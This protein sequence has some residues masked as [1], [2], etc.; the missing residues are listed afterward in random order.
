M[1]P[2][3]ITRMELDDSLS[4]YG[5]MQT[6]FAEALANDRIPLEVEIM[7]RST[8]AEMG[9][10]VGSQLARQPLLE[11]AIQ[12]L[13]TILRRIPQISP[14]RLVF[15]NKLCEAYY[16]LYC[17]GGSQQALE[18]SVL[19][20]RQAND[21]LIAYGV[22]EGNLD[23]HL[24]ILTNLGHSLVQ[25]FEL[26]KNPP[27]LE[28]SIACKREILAKAPRNSDWYLTA[29]NNLASSLRLRYMCTEED[30]N[31]REASELFRELLSSA[32]PGTPMHNVAIGQI[33][34]TAAMKF[35]IK[36]T[37]E[38]LDDAIAN[39]KIGLEAGGPVNDGWMAMLSMLVELCTEKFNYTGNPTDLEVLINASWRQFESIPAGHQ[40][41]GKVFL[42]HIETLRECAF[43]LQSVHMVEHISEECH[44]ALESMPADS[45]TRTLSQV[46]YSHILGH[47]YCLSGSLLDLIDLVEHSLSVSADFNALV[48]A[49]SSLSLSEV[50]RYWYPDLASRLH[51]LARASP[52][53]P[54]RQTAEEEM[55]AIFKSHYD[56]EAKR[57]ALMALDG[58]FEYNTTRLQILTAAAANNMNLS[59]DEIERK[60]V[61]LYTESDEPVEEQNEMPEEPV[62]PFDLFHSQRL[63]NIDPQDGH[64]VF[65]IKDWVKTLIGQDDGLRS[66]SGSP[67]VSV[68]VDNNER[69][70]R[71]M[72]RKAH[73]A[74]R[75]TNPGLCYWCQW[76][77]KLV[78]PPGVGFGF[79]PEDTM[80]PSIGDWK[81]TLFRKRE[82]AV[83]SLAAS[84]ITTAKGQLHAYFEKIE[85]NSKRIRFI[86]GRLP[87][88]EGVLRVDV[89][90]SCAGELRVL[91][92]T[93]FRQ[94]LRQAWEADVDTSNTFEALSENTD[95]PVHD[96]GG[97][98]INFKLMRRWLK[99]CDHNHGPSCNHLR[100]G[101]RI[102][103]EINLIFIDVV[104]ECL[105]FGSS[106]DEYLVLS[107]TWGKT[108]MYMTLLDNFEERRQ[109]HA[110]A[111]VPF[112]KSIRDAINLVRSL[113]ER[114]LW[115]DAIC[116]VQDDDSQKRKDI[117]N[118]D[119]V[120]GRAYATIVALHGDNADAGLPGVAP[121]TRA[122]QRIETI[123]LS[124]DDQ[125]TQEG[126]QEERIQKCRFIRGPSPLPLVLQ[127]STWNTRG[128]TLQERLLSR[129]CVY[130]SA[131]AFYFECN[132]GTLAEG[133]LNEAY[134][135]YSFGELLDDGDIQQK[136]NQDN[137]ISDLAY[138][139][140]LSPG[141]R[142]WKAWT[143]YQE[144][145]Q[146]YTKRQF[147]FK[148]DI[149]DGFAGI[150]AVLD[151]LH[152]QE[153]IGSITVY[154]V[155]E[156]FFIHALLW[157]PAA[158]ISR[159]QTTV[160]PQNDV[161]V[162]GQ[163]DPRFPSW[164]W[165]GW[166]GPV[167]YRMFEGVQDALDR[168]KPLVRKL[169]LDGQDVYPDKWAKSGRDPVQPQPEWEG[170]EDEGERTAGGDEMI[171]QQRGSQEVRK[172]KDS[173]RANTILEMTAPTVS[174]ACFSVSPI[175]EFLSLTDQVH[176]QG[177]QSV[178]RI[179]D[180]E[181]EHCGL[182]WSQGREARAED[183]THPQH[184][185]KLTLVGIS[186]H[187]ECNRPRQGLGRPGGAIAL[188]DSDRFPSIGPQSG[189]VNVMVV[190][191]DAGH[192]DMVS[193]RYTVAIIYKMAWDKAKP[194][195]RVIQIA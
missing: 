182:W 40:S 6:Q 123:D 146:M 137:P 192:Q 185:E 138:M 41:Q 104:K 4:K 126:F 100:P 135:S 144:L 166:D 46:E 131:D 34:A 183:D 37:P 31:E 102:K 7:V 156:A 39:C 108:E 22:E 142:L 49:S 2:D 179:I 191:E 177:P 180:S 87:S 172:K 47:K 184:K 186:A 148:A 143:V 35:R 173:P 24:E 72:F 193:S 114:L 15:L 36:K 98:Q 54:M 43:Q 152:L 158:K 161:D 58:I 128:W 139:D 130:F 136:P 78:D 71:K 140:D 162:G 97:Q 181:G 33:G 50:N 44:T 57:Y 109:P 67:S 12:H 32:A 68:L 117:P 129:R 154:G 48:R 82:C 74:G 125:D 134:E 56:F 3:T 188:W 19:Y 20:G 64:M 76:L 113:G 169:K 167:D 116:I 51:A 81:T 103:T 89:G 150:F 26:K 174:L 151:E 17:V 155:P 86:L 147:T 59:N 112:P 153:S 75:Q 133:G 65:D 14:D 94:A 121:G 124:A 8:M 42:K 141:N 30:E 60:I 92:P 96:K 170:I 25:R 69:L 149:L 83:C 107:Y 1:D 70:E 165:A 171:D 111:S 29:L 110:L 66:D 52:D 164:S 118:M 55:L 62:N 105:V 163:P 80:F 120:Y 168:P 18:K 189:W 38:V 27:D 91:T 90:L 53:N 45:E 23:L 79:S 21:G 16:E 187:G 84:L 28:D 190:D 175:E 10:K 61:E 9:I 176:T 195:Q 101:N 106:S 11:D 119:I 160:A 159:R 194:V 5:F 13:D 77:C 122:C 95:G 99:D 63:V 145:V 115:I 178:R 132:R 73:E 157:T 93:N 85:E 127:A 88:G